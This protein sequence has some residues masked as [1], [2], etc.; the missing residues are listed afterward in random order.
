[1]STSTDIMTRLYKAYMPEMIEITISTYEHY[2]NLK[3]PKECAPYRVNRK[4]FKDEFWKEVISEH[5]RKRFNPEHTISFSRRL[6]GGQTPWPD[7]IKKIPNMLATDPRLHNKFLKWKKDAFDL[8]CFDDCGTPEKLKA[9]LDRWN[10]LNRQINTVS[11]ETEFC[12]ELISKNWGYLTGEPEG[13]NLTALALISAVQEKG[14]E[15]LHQSVGI[16]LDEFSNKL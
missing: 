11:P 16:Y 6:C 13:R 5:I 7:L 4:R 8:G 2:R 1:M 3:L 10:K 12:H 9:A 15:K 14:L